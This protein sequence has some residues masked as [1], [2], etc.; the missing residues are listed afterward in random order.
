V[1]DRYPR[2]DPRAAWRVYDGEAVIVSPLDSTLHTLNAA[3]TVIWEAID[4]RTSLATIV[5]RVAA[6]FDVPAERAAADVHAFV[7][8]LRERELLTVSDNP[9]EASETSDQTDEGARTPRAGYELPAIVS[10]PIFETT[11]LA[12]GKKPAQGGKCTGRPQAS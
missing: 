5:A 1:R 8:T 2:Q 3:G 12:C 6:R 4:G 7:D 10:E 11:A 9:A